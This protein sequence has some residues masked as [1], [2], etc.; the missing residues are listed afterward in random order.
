LPSIYMQLCN[1]HLQ[2]AISKERIFTLGFRHQYVSPKSKGRIGESRQMLP[3][4]LQHGFGLAILLA[5]SACASTV[6][7]Q[8]EYP[9]RGSEMYFARD[10]TECSLFAQQISPTILRPPSGPIVRCTPPSYRL[11][12]RTNG[13]NRLTGTLTP[14]GGGCQRDRVAEQQQVARDLGANIG[15]AIIQGLKRGALWRDCMRGKGWQKVQVPSST[16]SVSPSTPDPEIRQQPPA[17]AASQKSK[18]KKSSLCSSM[19]EEDPQEQASCR[20]AQRRSYDRL[21]PMISQLKA[22]P[23]TLEAR[24]LKACYHS[25]QT[26]AGTD[27][28]AIERCFYGSQ[29]SAR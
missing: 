7:Q 1:S 13:Y 6:W 8:V 15:F 29:A 5:A 19:W 14:R 27:W 21:L 24:R 17:S 20:R 16:A 28:E 11:D 25:T 23:S 12:A 9:D 3:N 26:W 10:K 2:Q 18:P 4:L 22:K